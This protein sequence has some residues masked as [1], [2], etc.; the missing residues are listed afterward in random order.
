MKKTVMVGLDAGNWNSLMPFI[1]AGELPF[2]KKIIEKGVH[3][4]NKTSV[5]CLTLPAIPSFATGKSP[6][7]HGI[8]GFTKQDGSLTDYNDFR[9]HNIFWDIIG[10]EG[11]RSFI[12]YLRGAY[13]PKIEN[14]VIVSD[15]LSTPTQKFDFVYPMKY[16]DFFKKFVNFDHEEGEVFLEWLDDLFY[17][18]INSLNEFM[19]KEEFD[20]YLFYFGETDNIQ[21][22]YY[23]NKKELLKF[24]KKLDKELEKLLSK[25]KDSNI[26][27]FS[28]H[29][30]DKFPEKTF[31]LNSWLHS[32]GYL[33]LRFN[34]I[35][36]Y[37]F[38]NNFFK[39]KILKSRIIKKIYHGLTI[40]K[41]KSDQNN[42][43]DKDIVLQ[44]KSKN[45]S[46]YDL[47]NS[48]AFLSQVWGVSLN[49][50]NVNDYDEFRNKLI[51]DMLDLL[52]KDGEKIFREV[53][54]KEEVYGEGKYLSQIPDII[55]LLNPNYFVDFGISKNLTEPFYNKSD[56]RGDHLYSR[57]GMF[58]AYGPDIKKGEEINTE[59]YD[60]A[61]TIL[62]MYDIPIPDDMNGRVIKN[63]FNEDSGLA[64]KKVKY[65]KSK[66]EIVFS[67]KKKISSKDEVQIKEK[68][69]KLG[70]L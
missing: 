44:N 45:H 17:G 31:Y 16:Q 4:I 21:H 11:Y 12:A 70:Y 35:G 54:K 39:K 22:F 62:H 30:H 49:K 33:K 28:D 50:E 65:Q 13:P 63:I 37:L 19:K 1:K 10:K 66:N 48:K 20:F 60:F 23:D 59:I 26:I 8:F 24:Y 61:P 3:G 36:N 14:G 9:K 55:F 5:P 2:F 68:L 67:E 51:K 64:K 52:D 27:F 40:N 29:G 42:T 38:R 18:K 69:K 47:D 7:K 34:L 58:I 57:D 6:S 43:L 32:K 46:Y 15:G 53:H 56:R 41:N 25:F